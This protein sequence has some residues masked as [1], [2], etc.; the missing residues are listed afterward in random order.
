[1][2]IFR[3][4]FRQ[5]DLYPSLHDQSRATQCIKQPAS[6]V[7]RAQRENHP[8]F[9]KG[10]KPIQGEIGYFKLADWWL[11]AFNDSERKHIESVFH[12]SLPPSRLAAR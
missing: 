1:M 12:P 9:I 2:G 5:A 6:E 10:S 7:D 3:W 4:L 8:C 11:T